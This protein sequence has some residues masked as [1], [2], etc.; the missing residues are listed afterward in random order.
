MKK[1]KNKPKKL[2]LNKMS[3]CILAIV[4]VIGII[5]YK[6]VQQTYAALT[7][8][9][10]KRNEFR[11]SDLRTEIE[12]D[13]VPPGT[14]EP[15]IDYKKIVTVKNAGEMN[16]FVRVLA[17]PVIT[18]T[19]SSGAVTVLPA[20]TEGTAAVLTIDYNLTDWIDGKDGYFYYKKKLTAGKKTEPL[21]TTVRMNQANITPEY[22]GAV[23]DFEIKVEG[24]GATKYAYRDA[25]WN[26][27]T[28]IVNPLLEVDDLLKDQTDGN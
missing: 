22:V 13:F 18:K 25:W 23:L 24:I 21:F 9:D 3:F 10:E 5:T 19:A 11:I 20:T 7:D 6:G 27:Q 26:G 17:L 16:S 12:E 15:E 28:P 1:S 14:F 2:L 4:T 8:A